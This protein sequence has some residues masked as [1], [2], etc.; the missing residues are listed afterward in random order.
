MSQRLLILT[1]VGLLATMAC[2]EGGPERLALVG[3]TVIDGSGGPPLDDAVVV[4]RGTGIEAVVAREA[5]ELEGDTR[6]IDV[7][8]KWIIPGLIDAH[9]HTE[10]WA[11]PRYIA[12][13]VTSIRDVH[14]TRDSIFA[15]RD[16]VNLGS[17]PGPRMFI[18]GAMIDGKPT[19]YPNAIGV[20][21]G[22]D[23]RRAVDALAVDGADYVK[24]YSRITPSV[25]ADLVDEADVLQLRVAAHL[26]LTDAAT[27]AR[28]GVRSIE[29]M[30]GVP[31]AALSNPEPL[32][33]A[34]RRSF[35]DGWTASEAAW[36]SLDSAALSRVARQ[37]AQARV[38]LVPTLI[39]HETYS[40]LDDSTLYASPDLSAVPDS[41]RERWNVPGMMRR[42][43]WN[44][45][46]FEA[47]RK[48]RP[49]QNL[50][51][52]E[53]IRAGGLAAAGTDA[54]NQ[55]LVPGLSVHQEME[56]MVQAGLTAPAALL[57]ATRNGARLLGA[58]SLGVVI[59]GG[60]ADLVVLSANP[61]DDIS[62]TRQVEL[63][64]LRGQIFNPDSIRG[65]W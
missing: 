61:L 47:F 5:F 53:F 31:E 14:G 7:S 6:A 65:T 52:R 55:M 28:I 51:L 62:N 20:D 19:T 56:L 13:G 36:A 27:A 16:E 26:G 9:A 58:D 57:A 40:R 34:H 17:I 54:S 35:F 41:I 8:G 1:V 46:E 37:L 44:T 63:V 60:V 45:R 22:A 10:R 15:L 4:I 42:A 33:S 32:Y 18:S 29:H 43:G 59:P 64:V 30:T 3:A 23:A 39:L 49:N 24:T 50:F 21:N 2:Q 11:L 38:F 48:S 25:M 12:W